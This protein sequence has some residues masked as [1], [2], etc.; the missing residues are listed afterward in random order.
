MRRG[1][2]YVVV[3]PS[4]VLAC[5]GSDPGPGTGTPDDAGSP[6]DAEETVREDAAATDGP[7]A[8]CDTTKPFGAPI[9]VPG[10]NTVEDDSAPSLT[11]DELTIYFTRRV[12]TDFDVFVATRTDR[13]AAFQNVKP[14]SELAYAGFDGDPFVSF[15]GTLFFFSSTRTGTLGGA[16]VFFAERDPVTGAIGTPTPVAGANSNKN[17]GQ[18]RLASAGDEIFFAS[19]RN[20]A[21]AGGDLYRGTYANGEVTGL[22][23]IAELSN[24]TFA[25]S[26]PLLGPDGETLYFAT[27]RIDAV[28]GGT[29]ANV[30]SARRT[31][32][33][34]FAV[35]GPVAELNSAGDDR[36]RWMTPDGC[37][38]YLQSTRPG[39]GK[40]DIYVAERQ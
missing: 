18:A 8:P 17:D 29:G 3:A 37:R 22:T 28:D 36:P 25:N 38:I 7:Q 5:V 40:T 11:A 2:L 1:L 35:V 16:D 26:E 20:D 31:S 27:N 4:I 19:E 34:T 13:N 9:L 24:P 14:V 15:D 12:A 32:S 33:G 23:M 39:I 10:V 30:W 21:G 6:R